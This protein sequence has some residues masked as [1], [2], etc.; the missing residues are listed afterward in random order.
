MKHPKRYLGHNPLGGVFVGVAALAFVALA[1]ITS[2]VVSVY[3]SGLALRHLPGLKQSG[4][5]QVVVITLVP[6]TAFVFWPQE[7]YDLGDAFLS[8]NGTMHATVGGILFVD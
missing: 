4:W 2:S 8:Y 1:N 6:L 3:A 5:W 7:L